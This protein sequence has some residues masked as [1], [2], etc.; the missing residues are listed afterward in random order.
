M[1]A[2]RTATAVLSLNG[3]SAGYGPTMVLRNVSLEVA[4]RS[5]VALLGANG[6]GKT[7]TLRVASGLIRP[8]AGTISLGSDPVTRLSPDQRSRRGLCLIP[9]GRGIFRS[10]SVRENLLLSVPPWRKGA[11]FERAFEVFPILA[12]R[13]NQVA[14]TLSGGEQQMLAL[15]RAYLSDPKVVLLD[16]VSMGLAPII[17]DEIFESLEVLVGDGVSLLLV[18]QYVNRA[19]ALADYVHVLNCGEIGFS[20]TPAEVNSDELTSR[21]LGRGGDARG[22][23]TRST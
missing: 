9:E 16:E 6:A 14:G 12:R 17:V 19:L 3:V 7:T 1:T 5:V 13:K 4:P 15:A 18:E 21:Y 2:A 20:G 10:L 22:P 11:G 8:H 23:V